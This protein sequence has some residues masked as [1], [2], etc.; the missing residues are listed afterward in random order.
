MP[1]Y[2]ANSLM[3]AHR[4]TPLLVVLL[5][6]A[7]SDA[8]AFFDPPWISPVAPRTGDV[9]SASF[10]MGDCDARV[11]EPGFPQLTRTGNAIRLV[12]YGVHEDTDELCVYPAAT[13][14]ESIGTLAAGSYT[15]AVDFLYDDYLLGPTVIDI[16]VVPFTVVGAT[17]AA[18]VPAYDLAGELA[19]LLALGCVAVRC[20]RCRAGSSKF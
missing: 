9:I 3:S 17:V 14:T 6:L 5:A 8:R 10:R 16:G 13:G 19:L 2:V 1:S 20:L 4:M 7:A 18:P 12:V 11:E 15:L